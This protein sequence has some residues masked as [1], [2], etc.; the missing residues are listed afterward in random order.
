MN[1]I[2]V[3]YKELALKGKNRPWFIRMLVRNL[4]VVAD[5][6][7]NTLLIVATPPEYSVI[8]AAVKKMDIPSRQ[9]MIEVTIATVLLTDEI[10]FGVEGLFKGGAP[11]GR[12]SG[13]NFTSSTPGNPAVP[14]SG[15]TNDTACHVDV[16][17]RDGAKLVI[18]AGHDQVERQGRAAPQVGKGVRR[19]QCRVS[20]RLPV[21]ADEAGTRPRVPV[22]GGPNIRRRHILR[23]IEGQHGRNAGI[24]RV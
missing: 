7:N 14:N 23:R 12:G 13:G 22:T 11:S 20:V 19:R 2:V 17:M 10:N 9:V 15:G 1:A 16:P 5:K 21:T 4:Q 8:E 18:G 3:H 6:D 24:V